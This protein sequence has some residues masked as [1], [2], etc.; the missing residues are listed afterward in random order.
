M[1][2]TSK[3]SP[4][5]IAD[6]LGG[7]RVLKIRVRTPED[8]IEATR[9]GLSYESFDAVRV[10]FAIKTELMTRLLDLP[11]RTLARRKHEKRFHAAESDRLVRL[12]RIGALA[13]ETLGSAQKAA[14]W[15]QAPNRALAGEAPIARLDTDV[16]AR[17]VEDLLLRIAYGVY[18]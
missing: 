1:A 2:E 18:S 11:A 13:E 7:S 5:R 17:E 14:R 9:A 12:A 10:R 4:S 6:A 3:S 16:G 8:L 15:L